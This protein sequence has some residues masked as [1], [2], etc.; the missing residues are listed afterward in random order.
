MYG[1]SV[2]DYRVHT[3]LAAYRARSF[4][5]AA[6]ELHITQPAVSQ[7]IKH[8]EHHVGQTLFNTRGRTVRPTAAAD[9][10]YRRLSVMANDETRLLAEM[11]QLGTETARPLRLGC[12]RTIA[13]YV[14][15][16]VLTVHAT[17]HPEQPVSVRCGNTSEL[18]ARINAGDL[19]A[20]LVEGSYDHR[21]FDGATLSTEPFIAVA[22]PSMCHFSS[23]RDSGHGSDPSCD[24]G[25]GP[26]AGTGANAGT[27]PDLNLDT[28][29]G[30]SRNLNVGPGSN[31]RRSI[32][33]GANLS[34]LSAASRAHG[35]PATPATI[36]DLL[37]CPLIVREAGSGSR[38]ILE[39]NLAARGITVEDFAS[40]TEVASI[41]LIKELVRAGRGITFIYRVA[42]EEDL[43][44]G[45]L[46]D[47]TPAD[48]S[49][50]H[51][52]DLIWQRGSIYEPRFRAF[53]AELAG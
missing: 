4:T 33:A 53:L 38:E 8:L 16:R 6:R 13:D 28:R 36:K 20:A 32:E 26:G 9:L 49:I 18:L 27:N 1:R 34:P 42:V 40:V 2:L 41:P 15:P 29:A 23:S 47:I 48:F 52:F 22:A 35:Q 45:G 39:R 46:C 50:E 5:A 31:P 24:D 14:A 10:L 11:A 19:D 44:R 37:A 12:T 17:R 51:P 7:H 43:H 25:P 3:F 30:S 21:T